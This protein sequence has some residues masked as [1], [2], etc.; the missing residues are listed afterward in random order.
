MARR[1]LAALALAVPA[2]GLGGEKRDRPCVSGIYP[3][4]AAYNNEG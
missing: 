2:M 1:W 3:H 4:R